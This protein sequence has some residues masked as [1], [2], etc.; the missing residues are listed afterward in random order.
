ML[1][2][3]SIVAIALMATFALAAC[4][5]NGD[6]ETVGNEADAAFVADMI[7][8][9]EGAVEMAKMAQTEAERPE[10]KA[11]AD[12]IIAAQEKEIAQMEAL[13]EDL[14]DV[15]DGGSMMMGEDHMGH[16]GMDD[17]SMGMSM[18]PTKLMDAESFDLAFIEMMIPHHEGAVAM[19]EALL[20]DGENAELQ[21]MARNVIASQTA[22]IEQ[23]RSWQ[24]AWSE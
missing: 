21:A 8:H 18:D 16:M 1:R 2:R 17:E 4:S 5:G 20:E 9:H 15:D 24:K 11:M 6:E 23:M 7:P 10:L 22:E 13:Q 3:L 19:A 12:E 14:P